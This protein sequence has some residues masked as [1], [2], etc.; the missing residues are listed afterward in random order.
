V[1][2]RGHLVVDHVTKI[3]A[4]SDLTTTSALEDVSLEVSPGEFVCVV[5]ASGCGKST[6]LRL[7]AGLEVPTK[8]K[9]LFDGKEIRGAD[10]SRGMV[11]QDPSLFPW[12]TIWNNVTFGPRMRGQYRRKKEEAAKLLDAAG[13]S[14]FKNSYPHQ[15]S[16]GMAQRAALLRTM[17]NDPDIFLLDEPLGAL[18]AFTR[19]QMQ[20]ELLAL[21]R[22]RGSTAILI[23]HDVEEA[24]YFGSRV[25]VMSPR[26]GR[27]RESIAIGL[28][29]PRNRNSP[30]FI[31]YRSYI[32]E[33][34]GLAHSENV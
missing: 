16:G 18:D 34:L 11:F 22:Q 20:D 6:L 4:R 9:L 33:A 5:G 8:G 19:M 1:S 29:H 3:F 7:I 17:L 2:A 10:P 12:R 15:V 14:E 26:P 25:V 31:E 28:D 21:W 24:V 13:L 23:T 27:I 32:L 30:K